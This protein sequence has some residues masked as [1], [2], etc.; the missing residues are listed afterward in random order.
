MRS[1]QNLRVLSK[2]RAS[3]S[4]A[5]VNPFLLPFK[6]QQ[7][8]PPARNASLSSQLAT[9]VYRWWRPSAAAEKD[10]ADAYFEWWV[11]SAGRGMTR[12]SL[13]RLAMMTL[14]LWLYAGLTLGYAKPP[15]FNLA[16]SI[17]GE[18]SF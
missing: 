13:P 15:M 3:V 11:S 2:R 5:N 16:Y 14:V 12:D 6:E 4:G 8:P 1:A 7:A 10:L 18:P 9:A 17:P